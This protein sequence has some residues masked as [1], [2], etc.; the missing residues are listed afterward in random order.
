MEAV[1]S[2]DVVFR[3]GGDGLLVFAAVMSFRKP[4]N[5][6]STQFEYALAELEKYIA[7]VKKLNLKNV[8]VSLFLLNGI[9]ADA[10]NEILARYRTVGI[11]VDIVAQIA[12]E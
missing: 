12:G 7:I 1:Q 8:R 6:N 2:I 11:P 3:G 5:L 10:K 9:H 4:L